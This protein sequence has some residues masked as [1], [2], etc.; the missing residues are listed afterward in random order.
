[1]N[2]CIIP[3]RKGSK[4]IPGKNRREFLGKP[5]YHYSEEAAYQ[6]ELF[7]SIVFA[8]D[9]ELIKPIHSKLVDQK[10]ATDEQTLYKAI[11]GVLFGLETVEDDIVVDAPYLKYKHL[12]VLYPCA[13]F[14][15]AERLCEGYTMM[16]SNGFDAVFPVQR[17]EWH[18][19]QALR[20]K[21]YNRFGLIE[22]LFSAY[23]GKNS[24]PRWIDTYKHASQWWWVDLTQFMKHGTFIPEN[25]G[26]L[27][28]PWYEGQ[29]IDTL[30]DWQIAEWKFKYFQQQVGNVFNGGA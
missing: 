3:A 16:L 18:I 12:C 28:L 17:V 29:D 13:P 7:D 30:E 9:D 8:T 26:G 25:S 5:V 24:T 27:V 19:E 21:K 22:P 14:V 1:M 15:T 4:R 23:N 11:I 20:F 6:S 2:L 10:D